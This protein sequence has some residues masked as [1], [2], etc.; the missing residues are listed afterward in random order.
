MFDRFYRVDPGRSRG[1]GGTG[2]GLSIVSSIVAAHGGRLWHEA[3]P[4]G[5][6]TFVLRLPFTAASQPAG[7]SDPDSTDNLAP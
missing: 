5:G 6:A 7:G 2:L 4:G 1:S 3:T